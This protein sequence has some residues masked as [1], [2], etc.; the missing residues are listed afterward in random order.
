MVSRRG[1]FR[2]DVRDVLGGDLVLDRRGEEDVAVGDQQLG[3]GGLLGLGEAGEAPK[4]LSARVVFV[5]GLEDDLFPGPWRQP[6]PGLVLEAARLLYVSITRACAG[7]ILSYATR[8]RIQGRI[9][10][11]V[12][13]RFTA[14]LNGPFVQRAES[15]Q[16]GEAQQII[17][18]ITHL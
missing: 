7:C 10:A 15:L 1:G 17:D 2:H 13:S 4:G 9:V 12:P 3:A 6:Y 8:R 5:P 18:D 16:P 11:T 14:S